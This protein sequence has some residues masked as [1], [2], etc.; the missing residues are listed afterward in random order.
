MAKL[1][2]NQKIGIGIA[3]TLAAAG[4]T[5]AVVLVQRRVQAK[6][7]EPFC[8]PRP[9]GTQMQYDPV[10]GQCQPVG[11]GGMQGGAQGGSSTSGLQQAKR[12]F[13][14]NA[15]A[16]SLEQNGLL[17][18]EVFIP[19]YQDIGVQPPLAE[20]QALWNIVADRAVAENCPSP[21]REA[22]VLAARSLSY[23][24]WLKW[25]GASGQ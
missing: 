19:I 11:G 17:I 8:L 20:Q 14:I 16:L 4:A 23:G 7:T 9:D 6:R 18:D 3:A 12:R 1:S 13:C 22:T 24:A 5:A 25:I 10:S 21:P 2:R 15:E